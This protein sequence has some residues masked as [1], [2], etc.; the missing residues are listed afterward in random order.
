MRAAPDL[1]RV[2]AVRLALRPMLARLVFVVVLAEAV[3]LGVHPLHSFV[4]TGCAP[5]GQSLVCLRIYEP[6]LTRFGWQIPV[7][8]LLGLAGVG[9]S[10]V[11]AG[12]RTRSNLVR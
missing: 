1:F 10:V 11:L 2:V 6:Q 8:V 5:S 9:V 12:R 7:A 4:Q 3:Y